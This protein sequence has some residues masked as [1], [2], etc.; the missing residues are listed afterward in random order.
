MQEIMTHGENLDN[1][2]TITDPESPNTTT[3]DINLAHRCP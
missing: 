3:I 2:Q 1:I